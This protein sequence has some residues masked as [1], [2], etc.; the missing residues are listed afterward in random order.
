MLNPTPAEFPAALV[1]TKAVNG[2][3]P[4]R[5]CYLP[6]KKRTSTIRSVLAGFC[7]RSA[8]L[9]EQDSINDRPSSLAPSQVPL[10]H[11]P[12]LER[13][14]VCSLAFAGRRTQPSRSEGLSIDVFD[15]S[16]WVGVV[17]FWMDQVRVRGLPACSRREPLPGTESA[18]L[19][20]RAALQSARRVISFPWTPP[21]R[22][23]SP[24][25]ACCTG[26]PTTG[27]G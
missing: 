19:C 13:S 11:D 5:D 18:H 27:R 22:S 2:R 25:R 10:G 9:H 12:A 23:R 20:A 21:I 6:E 17:P 8:R 3:A 26:F 1:G 15:G 16:A 24:R 7:P 4:R 14:A